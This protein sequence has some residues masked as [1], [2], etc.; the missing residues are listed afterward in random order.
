MFSVCV[1]PAADCADQGSPACREDTY[2]GKKAKTRTGKICRVWAEIQPQ[3]SKA[4]LGLNYCR[5][6]DGEDGPWCYTGHGRNTT[7]EFCFNAC[8]TNG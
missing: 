5:N 2:G 4:Y 1:N 8:E 3:E 6:P 7:W